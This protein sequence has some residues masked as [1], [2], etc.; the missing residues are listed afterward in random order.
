MKWFDEDQELLTT[1]SATSAESRSMVFHRID[2]LLKTRQVLPISRRSAPLFD[3][4]KGLAMLNHVL[5]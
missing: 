5:R 3:G 2:A 1:D 4:R